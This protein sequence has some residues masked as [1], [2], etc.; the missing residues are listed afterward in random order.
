MKLTKDHLKK[1]IREE[2]HRLS[3]RETYKSLTPDDG[4]YEGDLV[5]VT[6]RGKRYQGTVHATPRP[7]SKT[8][9]VNIG[10]GKVIRVPKNEVG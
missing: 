8:V 1:I 3:E 5:S 6:Y 4:W 9:G 7:S 2:I 10:G